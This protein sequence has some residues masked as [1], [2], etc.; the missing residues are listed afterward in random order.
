MTKKKDNSF[1]IS[2][3]ITQHL[4]SGNMTE[5]EWDDICSNCPEE[6]DCYQWWQG[7]GEH[8]KWDNGYHEYRNKETEYKWKPYQG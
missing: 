5:E 3:I 7:D 8:R 2:D 6:S 1:E 4:L